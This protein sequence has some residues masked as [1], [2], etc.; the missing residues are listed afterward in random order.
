MLLQIEAVSII[1]VNIEILRFKSSLFARD[2]G[3]KAWSMA[4]EPN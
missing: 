2:I 3:M 1:E 4:T